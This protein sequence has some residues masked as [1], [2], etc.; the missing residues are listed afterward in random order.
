VDA[1]GRY[2]MQ[3]RPVEAAGLVPRDAP[4]LLR[5][6]PAPRLSALC[7]RSSRVSPLHRIDLC[8][9]IGNGLSG[10][11]LVRSARYHASSLLLSLD[12]GEPYRITRAL[13]M[14]AVMKSLESAEGARDAQSLA[15]E[16][17][18]VGAK[19]GDPG[20]VG[21][22]AAGGFLQWT[23]VNVRSIDGKIQT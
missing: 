22:A 19:S 6:F 1:L 4:A 14:H 12:S 17:R 5:L 3:R 2:L 13:A 11:D 23:G 18:T 16:A 10:I 15:L 8:W 9:T 21:W 7:A 20:A